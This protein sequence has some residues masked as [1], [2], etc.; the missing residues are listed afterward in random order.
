[1]MRRFGM[2]A[3]GLVGLLVV[4]RW[5]KSVALAGRTVDWPVG[6]FVLVENHGAV[7]SW[8]VPNKV[9]LVIMTLAIIALAYYGRRL[10]RRR[11]YLR[12]FG[13]LFMI[14]GAASN[15]HDRLT[16]GF[17]IDWAYLGPWWPVF[18]LSDVM[19]AVGVVMLV[20][21]KKLPSSTK[22]ETKT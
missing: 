22:D 15:L 4:D 6:R 2:F 12:Y 21:P 17:V 14:A 18:N 7:F 16:Y 13:V 11:E 10:W 19:I 9:A 5:L 8:P 1:M 3:I 20:W